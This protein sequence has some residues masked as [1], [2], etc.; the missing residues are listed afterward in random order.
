[1]VIDLNSINSKFDT[2][3][4]VL[5]EL[6]TWYD[7]PIPKIAKASD[8]AAADTVTIGEILVADLPESGRTQAKR[9]FGRWACKYAAL[10][11]AEETKIAGLIAE[12]L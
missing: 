7:L 3:Q 8:G 5:I 1:M 11:L 9:I 4:Y 10:G 12:V 2:I 6:F